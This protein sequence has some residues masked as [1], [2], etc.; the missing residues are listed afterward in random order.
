MVNT[1]S[2]KIFTGPR[3]GQYYLRNGRKIYIKNPQSPEYQKRRMAQPTTGWEEDFPRKGPERR[4]LY[5]QCG[6]QCFLLP[7]EEDPGRSEFPICR[8]CADEEHCDCQPDCRGIISAYKRARQWK[9]P[10][11][12]EKALE[13][14]KEYGCATKK[15]II[16]KEY[17]A[18]QHGG[19]RRSASLKG[20]YLKSK[21]RFSQRYCPN[22]PPC[23]KDEVEYTMRGQSK[24]SKKAK[25]CRKRPHRRVGPRKENPWVAFL[26]EHSGQGY[27][28]EELRKMYRRQSRR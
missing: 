6:S 25:C 28:R 10:E 26:R 4:L 8:K 19:A 5:Q 14:E 17:Q 21:G 20:T 16:R 7:D 2:P 27:T 12:A 18:S 11:V 24:R 3:G 1:S 9:Y 15:G 22:P 23:E 13:V